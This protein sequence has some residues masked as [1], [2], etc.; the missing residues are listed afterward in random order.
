MKKII[1][2]VSVL[3]FIFVCII[4][5]TIPKEI[6]KHTSDAINI[7]FTQV[8]PSLFPFIVV[9]R[10]LSE[11]WVCKYA[12]AALGGLIHILFG[13]EK[14]L[15][16]AFLCGI[17][18]GFPSGAIATGIAYRKGECT[19]EG[20][21][22]NLAL[23]NNCSVAFIISF[24]GLSVLGGYKN[25]II[26]LL[27][28]LMTVLITSL[29]LRLVLRSNIK[30]SKTFYQSENKISET[31]TNFT[32]IMISC[33]TKS[34]TTIL[35]ICGYIIV[36][37]IL[38]ELACSLVG[39][40]YDLIYIAKSLL[41]VTGAVKI[42][43]VANFPLNL[44]LC[45]AAIGFSGICVMLQISDV[46]QQYGLSGKYFILSRIFGAIIMPICTLLLLITLPRE[47]IN[48]FYN[49]S[50]HYNAIP[51]E[52]FRAITL[53]YALVFVLVM[54]LLGILYVA[55]DRFE[56]KYENYK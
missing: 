38:S 3:I 14:G 37:Y 1:N 7:C 54:C 10:I 16:G 9:S 33:I 18:G 39:N 52:N 8:I 17:F 4:S 23:C 46:C 20:A 24:A 55:A 11:T 31:K 50:Q 34:V 53:I 41:E 6:S 2:S 43:A 45:S 51:F 40:R 27:S 28:Q 44:V 12:G 49:E 30:K 19:K 22:F 5:V 36:F 56:K 48:V 13:I 15:C 25:A 21:E 35:N 47:A 29:L 32:S 26:L 42:T